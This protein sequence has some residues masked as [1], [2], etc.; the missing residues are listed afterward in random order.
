VL[1]FDELETEG[2][3]LDVHSSSNGERPARMCA[4]FPEAAGWTPPPFQSK[5]V[6]RGCPSGS[7]WS[8]FPFVASEPGSL[9]GPVSTLVVP[10]R[11]LA[12]SR[13]PSTKAREPL[14]PR[15]SAANDRSNLTRRSRAEPRPLRGLGH[16][17]LK[18]RGG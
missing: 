12:R 1:V 6:P 17:Q 10:V 14:A 13:S 11:S 16:R 7:K 5:A 15:I 3:Q 4:C 18:H 8:C 9:P 2:T